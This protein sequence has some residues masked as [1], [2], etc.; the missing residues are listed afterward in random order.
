VCIVRA[1]EHVRATGAEQ[2]AA[3]VP[4]RGVLRNARPL[5]RSVLAVALVLPA[6]AQ[7][8]SSEWTRSYG[9]PF[10]LLVATAPLAVL[11]GVLW[12]YVKALCVR[13]PGAERLR[14]R[15]FRLVCYLLLFVA[16]IAVG[17]SRVVPEWGMQLDEERDFILSALCVGGKGCPLI[18]NEMNQLRIKLG[19]LNR[20][21]MTLCQVVTPDP[22]AVLWTIL[23]F[24][25]FAAA[26][27]AAT[28]DQLLG[29]PFGL[30]AG[31]LFGANDV[32][33][34][35]IAAASNGAWS[36]LF[37][38]GVIA[39]TLRWIGGDE[40]ALILAVTCLAAASQLHGANLGFVPAVAL[41]A[42]W[43]RPATSRRVLLICTGIVGALYSS[44]LLYQLET[45]FSDFSYLSVSWMTSRGPGVWTRLLRLVPSLGGVELVGG[46]GSVPL[47]V[48]SAVGAI[49]LAMG[50]GVPER[51]RAGGRVVALFLVF[52]LGAVLL[53]GERWTERYGA[54]LVAP[55]ALAAAAGVRVIASA[56]PRS[57]RWNRLFR[58]AGAAGL[59]T[60]LAAVVFEASAPRH[61][62]TAMQSHLRL[63]TQIEAIRILGE[64][65][66]GAADME[67]RVHGVA[68]TR[69][70]GG[71]V[72]IGKWL[73]GVEGHAPADENAVIVQCAHIPAGF[74][75]WKY[76]LTTSLGWS[77][78]VMAG[79][80]PQLA[81]V[82]LEF[83]GRAGVLWQSDHAVPFYGQM[84]HGGDA[85]MR[86]LFDPRLAYPTEFASLQTRW[87]NDPPA[88]M[89]LT[90]TLAPGVADRVIA[91]TYDSG[92]TAAVRVGGAPAQP[93]KPAEA[94]GSITR[95]RY[96]VPAAARRAGLAIEAV[97]ALPPQAMVPQ[98]ADLY[99]EPPCAE[100]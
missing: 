56:V 75:E 52:P 60:L 79:Y 18:G 37:L 68:W 10:V 23:G 69:W 89:R 6:A 64:Q 24:H 33:L 82:R 38:V 27:L 17:A 97:I 59:L 100:E 2:H 92:L 99:E 98:R 57:D 63:A 9:A 65:G 13:G 42:I 29:F 28:G 53:I 22:R 19:P 39:G 87:L 81:P 21:L 40:R 67:R 26:W 1:D 91:L 90:T 11:L 46:I 7:A 34:H 32:L 45:G 83:I 72:Y 78:L 66:F 85:Q 44:W 77:P 84:V 16:I 25:A 49:A 48:L 31:V 62:E 36:S 51:E 43:W 61:P 35:V 74:A 41:A 54:P 20:Y 12:S 8:A 73:I 30:F 76:D 15:R 4:N 88:Q 95:E 94:L 96:L 93:V 50:R 70:D 14:T 5:L 86:I 55:A 80:R 3:A 71:Q 47:A 58:V